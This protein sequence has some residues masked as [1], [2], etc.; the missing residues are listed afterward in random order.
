MKSA[1]EQRYSPQIRRDGR[2]QQEVPVHKGNTA[3][4]HMCVKHKTLWCE[5][6]ELK[7]K[8]D[9][10]PVSIRKYQHPFLTTDRPTAQNATGDAEK[11]AT[12]PTS[13][14]QPEFTEDSAQQHRAHVLFGCPPR[15]SKT[16]TLLCHRRSCK[17][18]NRSQCQA[19]WLILCYPSTQKSD[20][21]N[22]N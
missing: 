20:S 19:W 12:L 8:W 5:Q 11:L 6:Q 16:G 10:P 7:R 1:S 15:S 22:S 21:T 14:N 4:L 3:M 13:K 18:L 2:L 9:Q 17:F